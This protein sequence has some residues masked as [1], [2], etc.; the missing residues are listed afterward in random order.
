M[1]RVRAI[2]AKTGPRF[3]P[4]ICLLKKQVIGPHKKTELFF[5]I[6]LATVSKRSIISGY[7][8]TSS[9]R[10]TAWG[11][12]LDRPCSHFSRVLSLI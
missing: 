12:G 11:L 10:A 4:T 1:H 8:R 5:G 3:Y 7:L 6:Y 2:G 9:K